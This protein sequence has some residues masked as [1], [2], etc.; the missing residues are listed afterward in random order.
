MNNHSSSRQIFEEM[1]GT[2]EAAFVTLVKNMKL[3]MA[4]QSIEACVSALLELG[5]SK[6]ELKEYINSYLEDA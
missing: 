2:Y 4:H 6:K 3:S 5:Y 1:N